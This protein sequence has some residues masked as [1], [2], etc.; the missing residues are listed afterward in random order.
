MPMGE[1]LAISDYLVSLEEEIP[2]PSFL[3]EDTLKLTRFHTAVIH[4]RVAD[5]RDIRT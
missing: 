5:A 2:I 1:G 3:V 4:T